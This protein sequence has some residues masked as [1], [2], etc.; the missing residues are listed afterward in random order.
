MKKNVAIMVTGG[1]HDL[2]RRIL[3]AG[4]DAPDG[5]YTPTPGEPGGSG[6]HHSQ[7]DPAIDPTGIGRLPE[8]GI[9]RGA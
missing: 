7:Y 3:E 8:S 4:A 1:R 9:S 6:I 2:S 5:L